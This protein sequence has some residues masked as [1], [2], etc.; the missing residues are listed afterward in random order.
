VTSLVGDFAPKHRPD[1]VLATGGTSGVTYAI[2]KAL[3]ARASVRQVIL[4]GRTAPCSPEESPIHELEPAAQKATARERLETNGVRATPLEVKKWIARETRKVEIYHRLEELRSYGADIEFLNCDVS[5]PQEVDGLIAS[6]KH[7]NIEVDLF[8]HGAGVEL[9]KP[10][11]SKTLDDWRQTLSPKVEAASTLIDG[12]EPRRTLLM[13]SV[14]GRFGNAMQTDYAAVNAMLA[15]LA[16]LSKNA[17][18]VDWTAWAGTGMATRGSTS[19][20]LEEAGV[21]FLP[22]DIGAD[23]GADLA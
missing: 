3:L 19:V 5:N 9:S 10:L 6:L 12:L 4:V 22:L 18:C 2:T 13:G 15:K 21:E 7:R 1:V 16:E 14:A 20:V 17:V 11:V 23:I 8:I